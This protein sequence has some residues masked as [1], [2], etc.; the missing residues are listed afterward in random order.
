MDIRFPLPRRI[1]ETDLRAVRLQCLDA[2]LFARGVI[3]SGSVIEHKERGAARNRRVIHTDFFVVFHFLAGPRHGLNAPI[4]NI[5]RLVVVLTA[6]KR[7]VVEIHGRFL[8]CVVVFGVVG[9]NRQVGELSAYIFSGIE[10]NPC[11]SAQAVDDGGRG[12]ELCPAGIGSQIVRTAYKCILFSV[13]SRKLQGIASPLRWDFIGIP[14]VQIARSAVAR[15]HLVDAVGIVRCDI[16]NFVLRVFV[17]AHIGIV[18]LYLGSPVGRDF[19]VFLRPRPVK[20]DDT[21]H[22]RCVFAVV[23]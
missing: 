21:V 5:N 3:H 7:L 20:V 15:A 12:A 8:A 9:V 17:L 19:N 14:I 11:I 18:I 2:G 13:E 10:R 1:V 23:N 16:C 6:P 22:R 4:I